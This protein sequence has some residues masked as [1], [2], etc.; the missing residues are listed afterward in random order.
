M[1]RVGERIIYWTWVP[2]LAIWIASFVLFPG[3]I[4]PVS[5][6]ATAAEVVELYR[7]DLDVRHAP[8]VL[9]AL[10]DALV[11]T[12]GVLLVGTYLIGGTIA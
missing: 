6:R 5:P 3:F 9:R 7:Q 11:A 10:T 4:P 1:H 8:R 2:L 12:M